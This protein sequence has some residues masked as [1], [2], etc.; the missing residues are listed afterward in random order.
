VRARVRLD[1]P[2]RLAPNRVIQTR[3]DSVGMQLLAHVRLSL[4]LCALGAVVLYVFFVAVATIS[5]AKVTGVTAV[6]ALLAG[7]LT[8]RNIRI[9]GELADPGGDPRLRRACNRLRERRGF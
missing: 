6:M 2:L 9:S 3:G 1:W 5:P 7:L 8:V 4:W